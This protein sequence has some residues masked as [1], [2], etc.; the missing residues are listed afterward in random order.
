MHNILVVSF[1]SLSVALYSSFSWAN[2]T[3]DQ[4]KVFLDL[5]DKSATYKSA[6]QS[7]NEELSKVAVTE[8]KPGQEL[9]KDKET[10]LAVI[11]KLSLHPGTPEDSYKAFKLFPKFKESDFTQD[12][13]L[14]S[15][16]RIEYFCNIFHYYHHIKNLLLNRDYYKLESA[17][18]E[19]LKTIIFKFI[20]KESQNPNLAISSMIQIGLLDLLNQ[21]KMLGANNDFSADIKELY[22]KGQVMKEQ[23]LKSSSNDKKSVGKLLYRE[24]FEARKLAKETS[25]LFKKIKTKK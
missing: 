21:L 11:K 22:N 15:L 2:N 13:M 20:E 7:Y 6:C 8:I 12:W 4:K 25:N 9:Y 19:N 14:L 1:F 16:E 17:D 18:L 3:E 24:F 5:V 10:A 23:F